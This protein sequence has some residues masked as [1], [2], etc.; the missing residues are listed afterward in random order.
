MREARQYPGSEELSEGQQAEAALRESEARYRAVVE[1]SPDGMSVS[2]DNQ[3]VYVNLAAVRMAGASDAAELLGR[4]ALGF[5]PR[6]HWAVAERRRVKMLETGLPTP[7]YEAKLRRLDGSVIEAEVMGVPIVYGGKPAILNSFRDMTEH[8]RRAQALQALVSA[9]AGTGDEFFRAL[10]GELGKALGVKYAVVGVL[11]PGQPKRVRTVALW[12]RGAM[13]EN[14]ECGLQGTPCANV[15]GKKVCHYPTDVQRLFPQDRLLAAMGAVSF[16]GMPLSSSSG[17]A[18]GFLGVID[19]RPM[20][21]SELARSLMTVFAARAASEVERKQALERLKTSEAKYRQLHESMMDAFAA[22][23]LGGRIIECNRSFRQMLG[24]EAQEIQR[25]TYRDITPAKWHASE[26]R[27][28]RE[29]VLTRGYSDVYQKEYQRKDGT[30]FPVELRAV[31]LRDDAGTPYGMWAVVRD[32][33][34]RKRTA[35]ALHRQLAFDELITR[36]LARFA[37]ALGPEIDE[38]VSRGLEEIGRFMGVEHTAVIEI[39]ADLTTWSVT[40]EWCAP[41]ITRL[42]DKYQKVPLGSFDWTEKQVLAGEVVQV[43]NKAELPPEAAAIR[44]RWEEDGFHATLQVPLRGG[45]GQVRGCLGLYAVGHEAS[46]L[47]E[48]LQRLKLVGEA[49]ANVLERQRAEVSLGRSEARYRTLFECAQDAIF[50]DHG[51][52]FVD[53]NAM[54]LRLFGC[55]REE[56]IGQTPMRFSPP[57]QPDGSPSAEKAREKL[58]AAYA[59]SP[60]FFE[61][62]HCRLDGSEFEA[63]VSLNRL[64]LAEQ[65]ML[66]AFVRDITVRKQAEEELRR[67]RDEL[68]QRVRERTSELERAN[69]RLQELDRLKSQFLATMSH[70]LRT[71]LNSIIGFTGLVRQGRVGPVNPEQARQLGLAYGSAKHLL[72]LINDLLDLSRV[73][74][75]RMEFEEEPLDFVQVIEEVLHTLTPM[76]RQRNLGLVAEPAAPALWLVGDRKRS[77]QVL[78][79]L[80]HNALKFTPRGRVTISARIERDRLRVAVADTGIGI[81]PEQMELLF[82]AFRQLDGSARR[83]YEGTGLGLHLCRKLLGLMGGEI[84]VESQFGQGSRFSFTLPLQPPPLAQSPAPS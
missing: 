23:E 22:V 70:E 50:L 66:L 45:G 77:Y 59:G 24:Y 28:I 75:G 7:V 69:A 73:E 55:R 11:L 78:L 53:C 49:I 30:V 60:Q 38:H 6:E 80:V 12:C 52:H 16:L 35:Q 62:R 58:Q 21:D 74:A 82:E 3:V 76:A 46:W 61:W 40:H 71:P 64:E 14:C 51:E 19:D 10:V 34:E 27:L 48:D 31:L 79:N 32:I 33:T 9:T 20:P 29:Q 17:A 5:V 2:V 54:T 83:L 1:N 43:H 18:L 56:I 65:P 15:V 13:L 81:K 42:L 67:A 25:L 41:G 26:E 39:A 84:Q 36:L 44:Q 63:E 72:S 57:F 8:R 47:P 37:S 68:E 4:S